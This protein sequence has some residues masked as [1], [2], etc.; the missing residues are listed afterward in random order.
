FLTLILVATA[1]ADD[2]E[3]CTKITD[4]FTESLEKTAHK[5]FSGGNTHWE[6]TNIGSYA[7]SEL[8]LAAMV[9]KQPIVLNVVVGITSSKVYTGVWLQPQVVRRKPIA[10]MF[11]RRRP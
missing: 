2:C 1:I 5:G 9:Q 7:T 3:Y 10:I 8:A 4:R 6:E 11:D